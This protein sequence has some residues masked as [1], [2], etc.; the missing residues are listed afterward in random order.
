M[1]SFN[2]IH[3]VSSRVEEQVTMEDPVSVLR[4][5]TEERTMVLGVIA[6]LKLF[7]IENKWCDCFNIGIR[8]SSTYT[9][10]TSAPYSYCRSNLVIGVL[11]T[12]VEFTDFLSSFWLS[13]PMHL[14]CTESER[15][16]SNE[17]GRNIRTSVSIGGSCNQI[18]LTFANN[19]TT[20]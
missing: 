7:D 16:K 13:K 9:G 4:D 17:S 12:S 8:P 18:N 5:V 15:Q 3:R 2:H 14:D 6:R 19:S 11:H 10:C 20:E 1:D